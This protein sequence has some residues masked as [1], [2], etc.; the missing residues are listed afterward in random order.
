MATAKKGVKKKKKVSHMKMRRPG[1]DGSFSFNALRFVA[2]WPAAL[3]G[4]S[5]YP[6]SALILQRAGARLRKRAGLLSFVVLAAARD[7]QTCN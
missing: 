6:Y 7:W 4:N 2:R 5:F 3:G 1:T